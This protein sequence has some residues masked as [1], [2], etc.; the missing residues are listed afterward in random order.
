ML[1]AAFLYLMVIAALEL[2]GITVGILPSL[3]GHMFLIIV[4]LA[5]YAL[6]DRLPYRRILLLL[7]LASLLRILSFSIPIRQVPSLYWYAMIGIPF[8]I[9]VWLSSRALGFAWVCVA[10][11]SS[12]WEWQSVIALSGL[13]LS[14]VAFILVRPKVLVDTSH[15]LNLLIGIVVLLI[16]TGFM[17]E[18]FF[19]GILLHIANETFGR[20]GVVYSSALFAIMSI[21]SLSWPYV[22]FAGL[23][24]LFFGWCVNR[25]HSVWGVAVAH[26]LISIGMLLVWPVAWH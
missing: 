13:P 15:F 1:I 16:F 12:S 17:E 7:A 10:S 8:L 11:P 18:I 9:A 24:G 6:A 19:R 25:T 21:G 23:V 22:V 20:L 26:G 2:I 5:Q 4:L 14:I 3:L